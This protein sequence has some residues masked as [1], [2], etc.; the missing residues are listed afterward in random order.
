MVAEYRG[1]SWDAVAAL[2]PDYHLVADHEVEGLLAQITSLVVRWGTPAINV[3]RFSAKLQQRHQPLGSRGLH[4]KASEM[5]ACKRGRD[6]W[7]AKVGA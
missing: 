4:L 7:S 3:V 1:A 6:S 2:M 5:K